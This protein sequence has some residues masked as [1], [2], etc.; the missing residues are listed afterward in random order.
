MQ[1]GGESTCVMQGACTAVNLC[2]RMA[3]NSR[4]ESAQKPSLSWKDHDEELVWLFIS[5]WGEQT[6]RK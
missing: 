1:T 2:L 5:E 4:N 3:G 6:N